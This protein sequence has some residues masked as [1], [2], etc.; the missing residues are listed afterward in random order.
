VNSVAADPAGTVWSIHGTSGMSRMDGYS[1]DAKVPQL[2]F[3]RTLL[4]T[5]DGVWTVDV[6]GLQRLRGHQWEFRPLD[7]L[8]GI[9]PMSPPELRVLGAGRLLIVARDRLG[10]YDVATRRST[11]VLD[12]ARTGLGAFSGAAATNGRVLVSGTNGVDW[13]TAGDSPATFRCLQY[14]LGQLGLT[15]FHDPQADGAGG[16]LVAGASL[17][18]ADQRLMGFDGK[19]WRTVWQGDR[20]NLRAWPA[21]N[22]TLWIQKG[23]DLFRLRQGRLEP[24]PRRGAL[25]GT[26]NWVTPGK[27]GVLLVGT[28]Q[29][30]ARYAPP[31]WQ[32]PAQ[33]AALDLSAI[34]ALEDRQGRLWLIYVDRLVGIEDG[35]VR[36]YP[37]PTGAALYERR[38][39]LLGDGSIAALPADRQ[40]M[41]LFDPEKGTFRTF[42]HPSGEGF[43]AIGPRP[44]GT[45]WVQV[46]GTRTERFRLDVFDGK[47]F[48][49]VV[50][51]QPKFH[52]EFLK[53]IAEDR[54]GTVWFG[55][56]NGLGRYRNGTLSAVGA[57]EG[58][59]A[60]GGYAFCQLP[61]GKLM[62]GGKDKLLEFDGRAWKVVI[63]KLDR[64]R[65]ILPGRDG[66]VWAASAGGVLKIR[67]GIAILHSSEEGLPSPVVNSVYEDHEGRIWAAT[68]SGFS[69]YHPEA[70]L[71]A[72]RTLFSE[73][74][75]PRQTASNGNV[76]LVFSG[77]DRWN[78]T[79]PDRLLY[80]YRIDGG[81]WSP[82]TGE[83]SASFRGLS[84]GTH[85]FQ[86]RAMDRNGNVDPKP[87]VFEL[88]VA[89]A[90][91][92]EAGFLCILGFSILAIA[93]LTWLAASHYAQLRRAKAAAEAASRSKSAFLANMSHE[94]R[95]PMNGILG[96]NELLLRTA[97]DTRQRRY[98]G[99]VRD[100]AVSLLAVLDD[101]LDFSKIEAGK[102]ALEQVDFDLRSLFEGTADLFAV[103]AQQKGLEF[104]SFI[105]PAAPT[106][107]RGDPGRLRQVI[108]NLVGNAVKFTERG[109]VSMAVSLEGD[110][111]TLRFEV[112]DT[113][114]GV[115]AAN[116]EQLF[117]PF[118]QADSSTTR[119]FGGTGLGLSIVQRIVSL[120]GGRVDFESQ[121]GRGSKFWFSVP[122]EK[123]V[124]AVRAE[125]LSLA[126]HS[127]LVICSSGIVRDVLGR[128][129][130]FWKCEFE[131]VQDWEAALESLRRSDGRR[132]EAALVDVNGT[133]SKGTDLAARLRGR[134]WDGIPLIALT[135]LASVGEDDYWRGLGF[136]ARVAKPLKQGE[137]GTCLG[138]VLGLAE[139]S[140]RRTSKRPERTADQRS[141]R[142]G[143]RLLVVED[144]PTN[145]E[146][147]MGIL[148]TLG[149]RADLVADGRSALE[150]LA[151]TD[152][153]LVL[154]DCQLPDLDGYEA[155]RLIRLA[156]GPVRNHQVP[157]IAMTAHAMAGDREKCLASGMDDY[158]TKP[159]QPAVLD[160]LLEKWL[161]A[162]PEAPGNA[163]PMAEHS[164]PAE[165]QAAPA[166]DGEDLVDRMMG[167]KELARSV[168]GT[169]LSDVPHQLAA[170]ADALSRSDHGAARL[171]AHTLKG[172]AANV[173][174]TQVSATA[175]RMELLAKEGDLTGGEDLISQLATQ[176]DDLR[177]AS[178]RFWTAEG[179]GA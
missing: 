114:V 155:T 88:S 7:E 102:L 3:P 95:T 82:F 167:N 112:S 166:F 70:D 47:S 49:P 73:K 100:S 136:A 161:V 1:V 43:G 123:Q 170:L 26:I 86:V 169:F 41:F 37:I 76:R 150:T 79:P 141:R 42:R 154:M 131:E 48:R 176:C 174:A 93:G 179:A 28:T 84:A 147:A 96:M 126:G 171:A 59:T 143:C 62:A 32:A 4:W 92:R 116:R 140:V 153:D 157:V 156:T 60:T 16:F 61:D 152:Y 11:K 17:D 139:R 160:E 22:G 127:V 64:V 130:T 5:E 89:R 69:V 138:N 178:E 103:K 137:L 20:A 135:P 133:E 98:A 83:N 165:Q 129:L 44:D 63:D 158:L 111:S 145:Q 172:A 40:Y 57:K 65:I 122:L 8:K 54:T 159:F 142:A 163:V 81:P 75:N 128:L 108:A 34:S 2:R 97:L 36:Q 66:T 13:C 148:E 120:M 51:T 38:P 99:I 175:R 29:G 10:V 23:N 90:W 53:F 109:E 91:Y 124:A 107:L 21:G 45:I 46:G 14:G 162:Q 149:Y 74:D 78:N 106:S 67:D 12:V 50:D 177:T 173:G 15:R 18:T 164:S 85:R 33:L 27:G 118:T 77:M 119:R 151:Q 121:K 80:S 25:L 87:P 39:V 72:P 56:P 19:A 104:V 30:L 101:V 55:G 24:A 9:D 115:G 58:Y 31:L 110:G 146:V 132:F 144:N 52:I 168:V 134:E 94:I 6:G 113:G 68:G 71:D 105:D 35:K 117:K 125:P